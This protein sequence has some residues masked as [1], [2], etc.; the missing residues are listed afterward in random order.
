MA[1]NDPQAMLNALLQ[2]WHEAVDD[3]AKAQQEVLQRLLESYAQTDY[4]AQRGAAQIETVED[5]RRAFPV[6]TY[7]DYRPLIQQVMAGEVN[8]LLTEEPVSWAITRGTT[9]GESKFIPMTP[10]DLRMRINAGRAMMN[11]VVNSGRYDLFEG[12]NLNLNFPSVV[13]TVRVGERDVEYG[14]SSGIYVKYV[15]AFTPIRSVPTQEEIDALGGGKTTRD[16]EA[17]FELAYEKCKDEN[18]TLVGGVAPTAIRFAHYLR[19]AHGVYPKDLWQTQIM[20]LGSVPGINT[21]YQPALKALYGPAA[22]REIYGATE[23]MFGQQRDERRAWVPNYDLFFFE[24]ETRPSA[25]RPSVSPF[26]SAQDGL[27]TGRAGRG[28]KMLHEMRPGEMGSLIVSTPILARY[29]IGDLI[30]AFRPPYFRCIG[31]DRWWTPW[32]YAWDEFNT[33]NLGRL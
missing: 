18:V 22:I 17:R 24:V 10:T 20:T 25:M 11:H 21:R 23:G 7:E 15:S 26:D 32:R 19:R 3:P 31:R 1:G 13:G 29:K 14:Y 33:F 28:L 2:P 4:G 5:Y 9:K 12:V 6:A 8:L 27:R 30:L 16:W